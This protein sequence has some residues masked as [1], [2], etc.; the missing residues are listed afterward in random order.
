MK[1]TLKH[2]IMRLNI[3]NFV[4]LV[5]FCGYGIYTFFYVLRRMSKYV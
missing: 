4:F 2:E 3:L 5:P 1:L